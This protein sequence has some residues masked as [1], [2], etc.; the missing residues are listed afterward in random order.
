M[1]DYYLKH[2]NTGSFIN[3]DG[4]TSYKK[5]ND[6]AG[7]LITP[8]PDPYIQ[9]LELEKPPNLTKASQYTFINVS[10]EIFNYDPTRWG[11]IVEFGV[12]WE[13]NQ[14]LKDSGIDPEDFTTQYMDCSGAWVGADGSGGWYRRGCSGEPVENDFGEPVDGSR[15]GGWFWDE[16]GINKA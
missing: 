2:G 1:S 9:I 8:W 4:I 14:K 13:K 5:F 16:F 7:V 6:E 10:L 3:T 12:I 11:G 15:N